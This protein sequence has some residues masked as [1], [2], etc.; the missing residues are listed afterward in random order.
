MAACRNISVLPN[1]KRFSPSKYVHPSCCL[2][3]NKMIV[4]QSE[5]WLP[6][7]TAILGSRFCQAAYEVSAGHQLFPLKLAARDG[8]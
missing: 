2:I 6:L 3:G 4:S 8:N 5:I 7:D 1:S